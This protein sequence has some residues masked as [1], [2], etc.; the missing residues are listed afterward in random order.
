MLGWGFTNGVSLLLYKCVLGYVFTN[1]LEIRISWFWNTFVGLHQVNHLLK[2]HRVGMF[3]DDESFWCLC[4]SYL[5]R[6]Y[7]IRVPF[8]SVWVSN[9]WHTNEVNIR[10]IRYLYLLVRHQWSIHPTLVVSINP[11]PPPVTKQRTDATTNVLTR[12]QFWVSRVVLTT[13][14][15][16]Y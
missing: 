12:N 11:F 9:V 2:W 14:N 13:K 10:Y 6:V 4:V 1:L 15:D 5:L 16:T 8:S 7:V 3:L